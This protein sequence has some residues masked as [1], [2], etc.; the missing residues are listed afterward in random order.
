M[1]VGRKFRALAAACLTTVAAVLVIAPSPAW[2]NPTSCNNPPQHCYVMVQFGGSGTGDIFQGEF[3]V[4]HASCLSILN[5]LGGFVTSEVWLSQSLSNGTAPYWIESGQA[6]GYPSG[7]YIPYFYWADSRPGLG[8]SEHDDTG[9]SPPGQANGDNYD[10]DILHASSTS[11]S[12]YSGPYS[13]TS[14]GWPSGWNSFNTLQAGSESTNDNSP[15]DYRG[16]SSSLSWESA[17]DTWHTN[18]V[19]SGGSTFGVKIPGAAPYGPWGYLDT[20]ITNS[21]Y[22]HTVVTSC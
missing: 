19:F 5:F 22:Q 4:T 6:E 21:Y 2:A 16:S 11:Y 15:V 14:T 3:D 7:T 17:T 12:V 1:A 8:Y 20:V 13:G 9:G 10:A 18:W